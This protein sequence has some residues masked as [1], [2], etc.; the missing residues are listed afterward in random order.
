MSDYKTTT[1]T[2]TWDCR[3][4]LNVNDFELRT[5]TMSYPR[6]SEKPTEALFVVVRSELAELI[7]HSAFHINFVNP[8]LNAVAKTKDSRNMSI[9]DKD[10]MAMIQKTIEER[11]LA[12]C[13]PD[14][15][16]HYMTIWT[17]RGFLARNRL[18]EHYARYSTSSAPQQTDSQRNATLSYALDMLECDRRPRV[19]PLT[20]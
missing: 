20:S 13:D 12:F 2:S 9:A 6:S 14:D 18:L 5:G 8:L 16:L 3:T 7:G 10:E 1:L 17:T 15:P 19:S 4:P 11:Y